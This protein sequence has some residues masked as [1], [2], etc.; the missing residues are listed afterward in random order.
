MLTRSWFRL[1][2][3]IMGFGI[4]AIGATPAQSC[5]P[6]SLDVEG[7]GG[8]GGPATPCGNGVIDPGE[9]CDGKWFLLEGAP[10]DPVSSNVPLG[11]TCMMVGQNLTG[12]LKCSETCQLDASS[13][14][15]AAT[16]GNGIVERG[17]DC[18]GPIPPGVTCSTTG[19]NLTGELKCQPETC[20]FDTSNCAPAAS[21]CGN[22]WREPG[23]D[24]DGP[25]PSGVTCSVIDPTL[26]GY[27]PKC[28]PNCQLDRSSCALTGCGN[29]V[30]DP[31]EKCDG[32]LPP[33]IPCSLVDPTLSGELR[34][35]LPNCQLDMSTCVPAN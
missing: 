8:S 30:L 26:S 14:V 29:G 15:V 31:G 4:S 17:E 1:N 25:I 20:K 19:P 32:D 2:S 7:S 21:I 24:C 3:L 16:C 22:G 23:E 9:A 35:C 13:C 33:G 28:L 34:Q 11:I 27:A 12:E 5:S 6:A 10:F 18:D